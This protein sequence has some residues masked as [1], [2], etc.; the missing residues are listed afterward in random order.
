M[1][2]RFVIWLTEMG[3][4]LTRPR[5]HKGCGSSDCC[6]DCVP[7]SE[8]RYVGLSASPVQDSW[9]DWDGLDEKEYW[10]LD[11]QGHPRTP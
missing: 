3:S 5:N 4:M 11:D 1:I 2:R 7:E 9:G 6:G 8:D 10:K